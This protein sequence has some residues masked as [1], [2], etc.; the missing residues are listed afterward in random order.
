MTLS[1]WKGR[2]TEFRL[3][4]NGTNVVLSTLMIARPASLTN[5]SPLAVAFA[6]LRKLTSPAIRWLLTMSDQVHHDHELTQTHRL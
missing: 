1:A 3:K 4:L 2:R 5:V 6:S